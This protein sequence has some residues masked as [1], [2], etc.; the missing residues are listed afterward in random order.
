MA[1]TCSTFPLRPTIQ[2]PMAAKDSPALLPNLQ[3]TFIFKNNIKKNL[4]TTLPHC[5]KFSL[6]FG[7]SDLMRVLPSFR[8]HTN[9]S[10]FCYLVSELYQNIA[11]TQKVTSTLKNPHPEQTS[12]IDK[13]ASVSSGWKPHE[14]AEK[15]HPRWSQPACPMRHN[16][17]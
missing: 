4:T 12:H 9:H 17:I 5:R 16:S 8:P 13:P 2:L 3:S 1:G 11:V 10:G 6:L 7:Y 14:G 15:E